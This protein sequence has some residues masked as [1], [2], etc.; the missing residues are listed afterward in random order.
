MRSGIL[1]TLLFFVFVYL[2]RFPEDAFQ[3]SASGVTLW[4][5]HVL[6]SLLPFMILSDFFI[7]TGLASVLLQK[8]KGI[9]RFLF[10]LSMYGSYAFLLGLFCGYPMGAKLTADLFAEGKITKSEAQYL[11]TICNF[12]PSF[13]KS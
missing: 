4:F 12:R 2:L 9:F 8:T 6:P 11:L 1:C 3:A 10:G 13:M 5:F 7:H